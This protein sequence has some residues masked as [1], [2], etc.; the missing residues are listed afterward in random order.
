MLTAPNSPSERARLSTTPYS[1]AHLIAG[2][3]MLRKACRGEAPILRA[4][5]SASVP[6]SV[7]TGTSSRITSGRLTKAVA[8]M[9]PGG[10]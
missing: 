3:V 5:C 2:S 6:I 9:M 1:S 8:M 4:A 10:A 7:S